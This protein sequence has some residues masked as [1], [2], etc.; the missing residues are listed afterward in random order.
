MKRRQKMLVQTEGAP[1]YAR[2]CP[3]VAVVPVNNSPAPDLCSALTV[4][5]QY[6]LAMYAETPFAARLARTL[7]RRAGA[8]DLRSFGSTFRLEKKRSRMALV[9]GDIRIADGRSDPA[10]FGGHSRLLRDVRWWETREP[11]GPE[12]EDVPVQIKRLRE[13]EKAGVDVVE[14]PSNPAVDLSF[15]GLALAQPVVICQPRFEVAEEG[16]RVSVKWL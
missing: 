6:S 11:E 12:A 1:I 10:F 4:V 2:D 3:R 13:L 15:S 5:D 9:Q 14:F 16:G 8:R 7:E